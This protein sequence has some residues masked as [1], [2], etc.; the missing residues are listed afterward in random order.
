MCDVKPLLNCQR[1]V[2]ELEAQIAELTKPE[3]VPEIQKW[4]IQ[5]YYFV[6]KLKEFNIDTFPQNV[7][8]VLDQWLYCTTMEGWGEVLY[9]LV[10]DSDLYQKDIYDCEDYALKAQCIC[11]EKY[12]LNSFRMC[13]G[14]MPQ[15]KHGFNIF[16]EHTEDDGIGDIYLFEPN[17]GFEHS[18]EAFKIGEHGYFPQVVLI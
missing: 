12:G 15:G 14:D 17:G 4:G 1:Q 5:R 8:F 7:D 18:G 3:P 16:F 13:I 9:D 2:K 6:E 10:L 11:A